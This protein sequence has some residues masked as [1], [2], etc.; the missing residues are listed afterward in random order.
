MSHSWILITQKFDQNLGYFG[1][2]CG[3][4]AQ[5]FDSDVGERTQDFGKVYFNEEVGV[6]REREEFEEDF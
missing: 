1:L 6:I 3:R 5:V 2:E 4:V